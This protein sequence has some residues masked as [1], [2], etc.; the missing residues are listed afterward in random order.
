VGLVEGGRSLNSG[1]SRGVGGGVKGGERRVSLCRTYREEREE[2]V[3]GEGGGHMGWTWPSLSFSSRCEL[4]WGGG[5][6]EEGEKGGVEAGLLLLLESVP[7]KIGDGVGGGISSV[8]L[9]SSGGARR[10]K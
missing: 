1:A 10:R 2:G 9:S 7:E 5:G 6:G 3:L 8:G 4:R